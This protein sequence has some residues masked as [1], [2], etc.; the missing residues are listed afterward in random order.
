MGKARWSVA[1]ASA[2]IALIG[3]RGGAETVATLS[4]FGV[5]LAAIRT[6][7]AT[8]TTAR[9]ALFADGQRTFI[10]VD[11][12]PKLGP[13][14]NGR[15][16][17]GCHFQPA[18]GGSGAFINEVR[19]RNDPTGGP[20]HIFASDNILR[21]GPQHEGPMTFFANGLESTPIGCQVTS[22]RCR[23]SACQREEMHRSTF[24]PD[25]PI[26]DPTS[27]AFAGGA[28]CVA[29]RQSTALFGLGFVEAIDDGTFQAIAAG[30]PDAIR[31]TVKTVTEYGRFRVARF[32][33]KDDMATLRAFAAGAYLN[34]VGITSPDQPH[35]VSTCAMKKTR[36]GVALAKAD[37]PEDPTGADGRA[38]IDRFADFMRA[39]DA[40]PTAD[41]DA[42]A[43]AGE[44]LFGTVGCAG[45][46]VA[47]ITTA[48]TPSSFLPPSTGGVPVDPVLAD[49]MLGG[50]TIHPYS[51]FLLH[52]MGALGDGIASGAAGP[53]MMR[54]APLWGVRAKSRLL[55]DGRA[56]TIEEAVGY[57]DG[58]AAAS[59]A[60]FQALP[61]GDR[62]RVVAFLATR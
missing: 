60:A 20:L 49:Q 10:E 55:H 11:D 58:Q 27:K 7:A 19:V 26:C 8:G 16:C 17:G 30:Q 56:S 46:H 38:D 61:D 28:N 48:A 24:K 47:T 40:P 39:L 32:G 25:L 9:L 6:E 50:Q 21:G 18:L 59:R 37:E 53:R 31:G 44:T 2:A 36:F 3:S 1:I 62:A 43:Q 54:T 34:E 35:E 22:P 41:E 57:H 45:C 33:W 51:D 5:P 23:H 29:E 15:S 14:F 42:D 4:G 52:D 12:L 13:V